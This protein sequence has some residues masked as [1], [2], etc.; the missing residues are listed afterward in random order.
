MLHL[1]IPIFVTIEKCFD[2]FAKLLLFFKLFSVVLILP[3]FLK[4]W[5]KH[6]YKNSDPEE[7]QGFIS[8]QQFLLITVAH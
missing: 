5:Q 2:H 7:S 8:F 3:L 1:L 6:N 4:A